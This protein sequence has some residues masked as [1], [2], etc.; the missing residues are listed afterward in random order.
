MH[1]LKRIFYDGLLN[2]VIELDENTSRKLKTVLRAKSGDKVEILSY[3]S[4]GQGEIATIG[5]RNILVKI[6]SVRDIIYPKYKLE[7]YQCLAK[8]EYMDNIIEKYAELG[9]TKIVPV[10]STRSLQS[11]KEN[12]IERFKNIIIEASL[13]SENEFI[14]ELSNCINISKIKSNTD[15]NILFHERDGE[16]SFP[17]INS[18]S[19]SIII[20]AEGGF[21]EKESEIL[22]EKGFKSYTPIDCILKAETAAV[23]F[24]GAVRINLNG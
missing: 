12:T 1:G 3:N 4:I 2:G 17:V 8:R 6:D 9:V 19:V 7:V 15:L 11:L 14:P 10:V 22:L 5:K 21:T 24:A 20:G 13:Q 16:K 18:N 23:L